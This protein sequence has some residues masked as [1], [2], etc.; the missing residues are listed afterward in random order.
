MSIYCS[1]FDFGFDHTPRCKRVRKMRHKVYEQDDSKPCTC[2]SSPIQY[3]GSHVF[4]TDKDKRVGVFGLAAI[5]SHITRNGKDN[6]PE[7]NG[8]H[9]WLRISLD[10]DKNSHGA[11]VITRKQAEKLRD[12]LSNFIDRKA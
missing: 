10:I 5:P 7:C 8:W 3:L 6:G 2:G 12:A 4:P 1:I 11:I 9:P